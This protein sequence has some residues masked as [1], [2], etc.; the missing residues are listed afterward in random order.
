MYGENVTR[1]ALVVMSML[2]LVACSVD[3]RSCGELADDAVNGGSLETRARAEH[4]YM[5]D[6]RHLGDL[7][8]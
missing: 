8:S 1:M 7:G 3:N 5:T 6:C 2:S 4:K